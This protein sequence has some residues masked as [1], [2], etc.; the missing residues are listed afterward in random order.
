MWRAAIQ[1][2]GLLVLLALL[3]V[4]G[5][6]TGADS[7]EGSR[8]A[9]PPTPPAR[10]PQLPP[11]SNPID[12][13]REL[14]AMPPGER[15]RFLT[16]RSAEQQEYLRQRLAEFATLNA[17]ERELRFQLL[18]LRH[19]LLPV[20]RAPS[21][22]RVEPLR[23]V[24]VAYR[25]LV[26]DRLAAWDRLSAEAQREL[27]ASESVFAGLPLL[28]SAG[29]AARRADLPGLPAGERSRLEAALS[30][31]EQVAPDD[32]SRIAGHFQGFLT[33]T[34]REK[35]K[36]L[37]RLDTAD[38]ERADRLLRA[39]DD[40]A[41]E[42]RTRSLEALQRLRRMSPP[43]RERFLLNAARWQAMSPEEREAWRR[44]KS[45]L[46]PSPPGLFSGEPAVLP[47]APERRPAPASAQA[48]P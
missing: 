1:R 30:R 41:P 7:P 33:L 11:A 42:Q 46:P 14:L 24:P 12:R 32:Q 45:K 21:T 27:L 4:A 13:F 44:L 28:D 17:G 37:A 23:R 19:Y 29:Q 22:N 48:Q 18:T 2:S 20:L 16:A 26:E 35:Q 8:P 9:G 3:G 38:R 31:W 39:L 6:L 15:E 34:E 47:P 40:L 36:T 25:E 10:P 43:E 5:M